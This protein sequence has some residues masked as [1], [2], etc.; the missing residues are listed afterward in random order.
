MNNNNFSR[1]WLLPIIQY[2]HWNLLLMENIHFWN[3][4]TKCLVQKWTGCSFSRSER[5]RECVRERERERERERLCQLSRHKRDRNLHILCFEPANWFRRPIFEKKRER[6]DVI[7]NGVNCSK[8]RNTNK[9]TKRG[10]N[11]DINRGTH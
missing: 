1:M 4:S 5:E 6:K 10:R 2:K 8:G 7:T 9:R 3:F 11:I